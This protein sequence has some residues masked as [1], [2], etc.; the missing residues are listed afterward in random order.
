VQDRLYIQTK[1][2]LASNIQSIKIHA[3]DGKLVKY[4][5]NVN[6]I[7]G[8]ISLDISNLKSA[9]YFMTVTSKD[10]ERATYKVLV[11]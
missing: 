2:N 10:A 4:E 7:N 6:S 1:G 3:I 5:N 9:M 11:K 8:R